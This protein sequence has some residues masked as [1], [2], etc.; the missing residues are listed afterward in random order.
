MV[1]QERYPETA[2]DLFTTPEIVA[3]QEDVQQT[4]TPSWVPSV[5]KNLGENSGKLRADEWRIIGALYLPITLT[6]LWSRPG[7]GD[8]RA[9]FRLKL[10]EATNHL[11]SA[12][13]IAT[14]RETSELHIKQYSEHIVSYMRLIHA[15]VPEYKFRPNHHLAAHIAD[16]LCYY[17]PVNG[18]WTFPFERL[19]GMLERTPSNFKTGK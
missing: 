12:V 2:G 1:P 9:V 6:R 14:S 17:G 8:V 4:I 11:L 5:P 19:I 3:L 15:V 18:W 10:L 16:H 13:N 7:P